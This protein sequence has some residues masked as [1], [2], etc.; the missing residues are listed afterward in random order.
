MLRADMVSFFSFRLGRHEQSRRR[1]RSWRR[2]H[3]SAS[4]HPVRFGRI[5]GLH[6]RSFGPEPCPPAHPANLAE[7][8]DLGGAAVVFNG[9]WSAVPE[10]RD[11]LLRCAR[12]K[13][14]IIADQG[15]PDVR[16]LKAKAST[17]IHVLTLSASTLVRSEERRGGK[18]GR[19]R[20]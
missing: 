18:E 17:P 5:A 20:W 1:K 8:V 2:G 3:R 16:Y 14:V 9:V 11:D 6:R 15:T 13:H 7:G 12:F 19:Y 4:P 10:V